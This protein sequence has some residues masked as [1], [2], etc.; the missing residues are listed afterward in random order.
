LIRDASEKRE[1]IQRFSEASRI[2]VLCNNPDRVL[3]ARAD[4]LL[5]EQK[6]DGTLGV[7]AE[8]GRRLTTPGA[9][10]ERATRAVRECAMRSEEKRT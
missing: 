2:N 7:C 4:D 3:I 9:C 8:C 1:A 10:A 5:P 6:V